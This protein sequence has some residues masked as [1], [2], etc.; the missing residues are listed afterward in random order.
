MSFQITEREAAFL[1]VSCHLLIGSWRH[2]AWPFYFFPMVGKPRVCAQRSICFS[3]IPS[4]S[5]LLPNNSDTC[6]ADRH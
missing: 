6:F 4:P 3:F 2:L 1:W 5:L